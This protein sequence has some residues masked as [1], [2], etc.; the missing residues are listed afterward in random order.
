VRSGCGEFGN[1]VG[2]SIAGNSRKFEIGRLARR[3]VLAFSFPGVE[4]SAVQDGEHHLSAIYRLCSGS[5]L[6]K[7]APRDLASS[8][9]R[10]RNS[11]SGPD[12]TNYTAKTCDILFVNLII[13]HAC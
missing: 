12:R 2:S 13:R 8:E 11:L 1:F 7:T 6:V 5:Q 10:K 4:G 3:L 9:M